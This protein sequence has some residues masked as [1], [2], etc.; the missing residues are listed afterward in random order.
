MRPDVQI[1]SV[2]KTPLAGIYYLRQLPC[3][4]C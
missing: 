1:E 4:Q 2:A 3:P